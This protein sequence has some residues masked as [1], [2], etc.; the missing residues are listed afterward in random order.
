[1]K[2]SNT[3]WPDA[4]KE[5]VAPPLVT[6]DDFLERIRHSGR[7]KAYYQMDTYMSFH[8]ENG[9]YVQGMSRAAAIARVKKENAEAWEIYRPAHAAW[10][11]AIEA[12]ID[13]FGPR[14]DGEIAGGIGQGDKT[15]RLAVKYVQCPDG[16]G[17]FNAA[18]HCGSQKWTSHGRSPLSITDAPM[19]AVNCDKCL[20]IRV[21]GGKLPPQY[22]CNTCSRTGSLSSFYD[23]KP[24]AVR[25]FLCP[26]CKSPHKPTPLVA[27]KKPAID[28]M[29]RPREFTFVWLE[30]MDRSSIGMP[31]LIG[32]KQR[33][34]ARAMTQEEAW[35]K[36]EK[37]YVKNVGMP[38]RIYNVELA[39]IHAW[40]GAPL[41]KKGMPQQNPYSPANT[42]EQYQEWL[43][44]YKELMWV[45]GEYEALAK[46]GKAYPDHRVN[47]LFNKLSSKYL[48]IYHD[49]WENVVWWL[50]EMADDFDCADSRA[51]KV[52]AIDKLMHMQHEKGHI[53]TAIYGFYTT[54]P[55]GHDLA[56]QAEHEINRV[57]TRL[58]NNPRRNPESDEVRLKREMWEAIGQYRMLAYRGKAY[59][60][61]SVDHLFMTLYSGF[62]ATIDAWTGSPFTAEQTVKD[63]VKVYRMFQRA[64][65]RQA[66]VIAIDAL[67]HLQ[68]FSGP[69]IMALFR[70]D[71]DYT[72]RSVAET[73]D[74]LSVKNPVGD[75][76]YRILTFPEAKY[77][78][79][80][81]GN[82]GVRGLEVLTARLD[83]K[84]ATAHIGHFQIKKTYRGKG[85]GRKLVQQMEDWMRKEG[86]KTVIGRSYV[87]KVSFWEHMGYKA[88]RSHG[89]LVDVK[90]VL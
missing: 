33:G 47:L 11:I 58:A 65:T 29:S 16:A 34:S 57:L 6:D 85:L 71:D 52:I 75:S 72:E 27:G 62:N 13:S 39:A 46:A 63:I 55:A 41:W 32:A 69:V 20:G 80:D 73:L 4:P 76:C 61:A 19:N 5:P 77:L 68:H 22:K 84:T 18:S 38:V 35:A 8:T 54:I 10:E 49:F 44:G 17:V 31:N 51:G 2:I 60:D 88:G 53:L 21:A 81:E 12:Y 23:P 90:K 30:D 86:M 50:D 40:N 48:Q 74:R 25:R 45:I 79:Y 3:F 64:K 43:N 1:M 36:L 42:P 66:K 9:H 28:P 67:M 83:L 89:G 82:S 70:V 59:P 7:S 24:W 15:H 26:Q 87:W 56:V 37:G 78:Y 14:L